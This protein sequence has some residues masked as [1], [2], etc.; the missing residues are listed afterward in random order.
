MNHISN[1]GNLV[2]Y[3]VSKWKWG[4]LYSRVLLYFNE[5][6]PVASYKGNTYKLWS[7]IR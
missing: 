5:E 4:L 1:M 3:T 2:S 6:K 7:D